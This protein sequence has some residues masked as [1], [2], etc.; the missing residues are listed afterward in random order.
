MPELLKRTYREQLATWIGKTCHFRLLYKISRD[1]C[2]ATTFHQQCDNQGPTV[3]V[4]YN[5]NNTIFGGYLSQNWNSSGGNISD[6]NAFLFRLQYNGSSNPVKL[7]VNASYYN[8]AG[9][10]IS[11]YGPSFGGN[12]DL[13][14]FQGNISK[15]GKEFVLNGSVSLTSGYYNY[16][17]YDTN[18]ITNSNLRVTDLEVYLVVD[19]PGPK[20]SDKPWRESPEWNTET[21]QKLNQSLID[22][23]PMTETNVTTGNILL[24]GQIGAGKSSFFNS[25]NS[26]FRGKITS[27]ASSGNFEHSVTTAYRKYKIK[28]FSSGKFLNF[29][30]CDTRGLEE[31]FAMDVQEISFLL[32]GNIPDRY[33]FNPM[34]PFTSETP[35]YIKDPDLQDKIHCVA[36]VVDSST[37]DVMPDKVRKQMK[38]LQVKL[39]QRNL[40]Q[41]V[42]LTKL[43]KICPEVEEDIKNTFS[44]SA[45]SDAVV[46]VAEIMGLP[47]GHV[48]PVK[49]YES[50]TKLKTG[51]DILVMEALQQCLDFADDFMD[52]QLDKMATDGKLKKEKD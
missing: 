50:E 17:G 23:K 21:C 12:S 6:A 44:S 35:G 49:N 41:V 11:N 34:V 22:Y 30:L 4:L 48:L 32:D 38:D 27:K 3:T 47:R 42:L 1:G 36:F 29:R 7:P 19:G 5:T 43:D 40:P 33:Q 28:D 39:N 9:S 15:S 20:I 24:I 51:V 16:N 14:A 26:I 31:E 37:V 46:R 8:Y 18:S 2:S 13:M 25:V 45:V 52:E 10:G